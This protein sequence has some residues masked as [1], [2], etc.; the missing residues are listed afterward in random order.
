MKPQRDR[1]TSRGFSSAATA[2]ATWLGSQELAQV[3]RPHMA[4]ARWAQIVGPQV[5]AVTEVQAVRGGILFVHVKNSVWAQELTMLREDIIRRLNLDLGGPVITSIQFN[6]SGFQKIEVQKQETSSPLPTEEEVRSIALPPEKLLKITQSI[7]NITDDAL[8]ERM[9]GTLQRIA[10]TAE[11]KRSHQWHPCAR[12]EALMPP[13]RLLCN[14]CRV[15]IG[16]YQS[17]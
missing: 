14:L 12:C 5:D 11:W 7:Q 15:G 4:K 17:F 13:E 16:R 1:R 2:A 10:Q 6:G 3:L 8:R 9:S